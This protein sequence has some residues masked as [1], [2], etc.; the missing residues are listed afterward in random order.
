VSSTSRSLFPVL[1]ALDLAFL[2]KHTPQRYVAE[3]GSSRHVKLSTLPASV[4]GRGWGA[5]PQ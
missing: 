2:A 5:E 1:E 3:G 4:F